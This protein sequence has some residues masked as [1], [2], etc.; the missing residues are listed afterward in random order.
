MKRLILSPLVVLLLLM[1]IVG[2]SNAVVVTFTGGTATLSDGTTVTPNN[3]G[4][5]GD[6]DYYVESGVKYDFVGGYGTVGDYYSIGVGGFVGNDV[7]HAHWAAGGLGTITSMVITKV[8]GS[9]F[10]LNYVDI[11]SNTTTGGGQ[12]SDNELSYITNHS[13][14]SM[15]L[16]SSDWGFA[17]DY[18]GNIGDG[19][20]RLWLDSFFKGVT[21]VTFTSQNAACFGLDNFY[22]DEPAPPPPVPEPSTVLLFGA[23]LLGLVALR[24]RFQE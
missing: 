22:I 12:D 23:G 2:S 24:K 8:D 3:S 17:I 19:V 7:I 4:Y 14:H 1:G 9:A 10:D 11:T 18:Y 13:G 6:V 16:P 15:L 20:A 21:S 5:W